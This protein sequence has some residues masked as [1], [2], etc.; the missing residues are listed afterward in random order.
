MLEY[1][2]VAT[3]T[4]FAFFFFIPVRPRYHSDAGLCS[5]LSLAGCHLFYNFFHCSSGSLPASLPSLELC[6]LNSLLGNNMFF[7]DKKKFFSF[8]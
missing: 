4:F 8:V 7:R 5:F 3:A 6:Y 2:L 1:F